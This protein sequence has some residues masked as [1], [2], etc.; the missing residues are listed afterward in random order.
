MA[1]VWELRMLLGHSSVE[2]EVRTQVG[3]FERARAEFDLTVRKDPIWIELYKIEE[4]K[5]PKRI[6]RYQ[7]S[8]PPRARKR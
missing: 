1:I 6:K 7:R 3:D 5:A 2:P 4:G 8:M